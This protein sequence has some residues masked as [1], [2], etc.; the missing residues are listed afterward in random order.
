MKKR[1]NFNKNYFLA[2]V[3]LF[4]IL[5]VIA[6]FVNDKFIRPTVGDFLVVIFIYCFFKSFWNASSLKV[7]I[8]V[9][10]FAY[11]VEI[12]QYFDLVKLLSLEHSKLARV[13]IGTHFVWNDLVAYTLG[14]LAVLGIEKYVVAQRD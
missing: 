5:V 10:L 9:L 8:C 6:V 12:G 11:A 7:G 2:A 14:V 1:F 13:V 3:L 4:I